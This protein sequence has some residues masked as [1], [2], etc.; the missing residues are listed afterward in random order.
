MN[1]EKEKYK[2]IC[3]NLLF[4]LFGGDKKLI[5]EWW[6]TNNKRYNRTPKEQWEINYKEVYQQLMAAA[7][8][9][10]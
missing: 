3:D 8:G 5:N 6:I 10:W 1:N 2:K 4:S 7:Y 9:E